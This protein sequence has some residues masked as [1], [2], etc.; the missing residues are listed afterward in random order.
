MNQKPKEKPSIAPK[1]P[2]DLVMGELL[3][4]KMA[5]VKGILTRRL[6]RGYLITNYR[7]FVWDAESDEMKASVPIDRCEVETFNLKSGL[8]SKRGGRFVPLPPNPGELPRTEGE[9]IMGAKVQV[10]D[11]RFL[12]GGEAIMVFREV[13]E[14]E[15]VRQ[16]V[17]GLRA[18]W[19]PPADQRVEEVV[20][21]EAHHGDQTQPRP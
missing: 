7:C 18:A 12:V 16:L 6:I 3:L 2:T 13:T 4:W 17:E 21:Q 11:L 5:D 15:R 1:H 8:K 10:G 20:R 14:P 19:K 9:L